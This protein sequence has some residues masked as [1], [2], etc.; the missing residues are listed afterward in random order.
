M[1]IVKIIGS[2]L[3]I[4]G[5]VGLMIWSG[6]RA[7]NQTST[8]A[9]IIINASGEPTLLT[10]SDILHI[11]KQNNV[12]WE[13]KKIKE[14]ELASINKILAQE[15]YIKSVDKVHFSGSKLQIEVSLHDILLEV[16]SNTGEKFLLDVEGT[17]LPYSP[18]AGNDVIVVNGF[19]NNTFRKN[20]IVTPENKELYEVFTIASL[21]KK[22]PF[23]SDLFH[24]MYVNDKQEVVL[25]PSVGKLPV[26]FGTMQD[27]ESKLKTLKRMY[28]EVI[29]YMAED[30]Y[31]QL[32]VRFKNRIVA[33]KSKS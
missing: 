2:F 29:L 11:L 20:E 17:Y 23:Y 31:A 12:E 24:K 33:K 6:I 3:L 19:I 7:N 16:N 28:E 32:D 26:L 18:K 8:G 30:K 21:I 22:D 25:H 4:L 1:K 5:I 9:S 10:E 14:V 13:G 27:A 15:K